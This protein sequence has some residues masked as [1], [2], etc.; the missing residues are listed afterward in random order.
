MTNYV[1]TPY[2][3]V[4]PLKFGMGRDEIKGLVGNAD[5]VG[6][7]R[8]EKTLTEYRFGNSL[9]LVYDLATVRLVCISLHRPLTEI[10]VD[11]IQLEWSESETWLE[12]LKKLD[13]DPRFTYG[14]TV[15]FKFGIS[16][17]GLQH[18][19]NGGKSVTAFARGQWDS[20]SPD[21]LPA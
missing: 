16:A 12:R 14:I 18:D 9:Q 1:I 21:L 17:A 13:A 2:E 15:L 8:E 11:G 20:D 10:S 6:E 19:E 5:H 7:D 4:G 3:G